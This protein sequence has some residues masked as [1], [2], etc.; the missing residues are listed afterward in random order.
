MESN[1]TV[2]W[3]MIGTAVSLSLW[4]ENYMPPHW[5]IRGTLILITIA[6]W[7]QV[8]TMRGWL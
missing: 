4:L 2:V 3:F 1:E 7:L 5:V 6:A 8:A